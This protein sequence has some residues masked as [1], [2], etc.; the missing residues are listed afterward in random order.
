MG[1][2]YIKTI[3]G[4]GGQEGYPEDIMHLSNRKSAERFSQCVGFLV[5]ETGQKKD[6]KK[7]T[8]AIFAQGLIK[9]PKIKTNSGNSR[10]PFYVEITINKRTEPDH[11]VP[12]SKIRKILN[13]PNEHMQR[14]GG[15]I[16]ITK[17]QFDKINSML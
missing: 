12:L 6:N 16:K 13:S 1:E 5:Y 2:Y 15:L 14:W 11:G 10:F 8:K 17:E 9:N 7:G 3:W 4:P